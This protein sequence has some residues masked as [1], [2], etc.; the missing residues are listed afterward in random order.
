MGKAEDDSIDANG[1]MI[2]QAIMPFSKTGKYSYQIETTHVQTYQ[3]MQLLS[4]IGGLSKSVGIIVAI[5]TSLVISRILKKELQE[6][7]DNH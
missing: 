4:D 3:I 1:T 2:Y 7:S 5:A 6:L